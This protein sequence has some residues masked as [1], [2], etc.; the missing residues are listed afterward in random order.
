MHRCVS[1]LVVLPLAACAQSFEGRIAGRLAEAGLSRPVA[2]CMADRWVSRLNVGQ[3]QRI[4]SLAEDLQRE[5]GRGQLTIAR[6]VER[7]AAVG[8]PE[9]LTVVSSSAAV[10]ALS[11]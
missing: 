9:I 6:F 4:S 1:L 5:R 10:C 8:D 7:V 2:E 11:A 3:L